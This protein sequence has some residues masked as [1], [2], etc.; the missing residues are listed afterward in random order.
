M[1]IDTNL[2]KMFRHI[3]K[4]WCRQVLAEWHNPS[5]HA[6]HG[7]EISTPRNPVAP[8]Y[9]NPTISGRPLENDVR[10]AE[11]A[12]KDLD[13]LSVKVFCISTD[14]NLQQYQALNLLYYFFKS[15][16]MA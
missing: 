11:F 5:W 13:K 7:A 2:S 12:R 1:L 10:L 4:S 9:W 16:V 15:P 8:V 3:F 14:F 6:K